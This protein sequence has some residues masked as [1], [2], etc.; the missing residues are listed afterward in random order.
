MY[1]RSL[2]SGQTAHVCRLAPAFPACLYNEYQNLIC[3]LKYTCMHVF[4]RIWVL[5]ILCKII[6]F[7]L[8]H[9][10]DMLCKLLS[11]V[12]VICC[13]GVWYCECCG[14]YFFGTAF[15]KCIKSAQWTA[16]ILKALIFLWYLIIKCCIGYCHSMR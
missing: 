5:I 14:S 13:H 15:Q 1:G 6:C 12:S 4:C 9:T 11:E 10:C 3:W 2:G 7:I 16:I 8:V